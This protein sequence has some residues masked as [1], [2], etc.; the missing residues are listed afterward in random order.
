[1]TA[2]GATCPDCSERLSE[3]VSRELQLSVE[4]EEAR[5]ELRFAFGRADQYD[6]TVFKLEDGDV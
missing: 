2:S 1:L 3:H 6:R 4:D 5:Q